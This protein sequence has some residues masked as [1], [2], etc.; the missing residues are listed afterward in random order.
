MILL[1]SILDK[2]RALRTL[3]QAHN[4]LLFLFLWPLLHLLLLQDLQWWPSSML[5]LLCQAMYRLPEERPLLPVQNI[6]WPRDYGYQLS[7]GQLFC[8]LHP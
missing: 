4:I 8:R 2:E 1:V 6:R 5:F 7:L 3:F